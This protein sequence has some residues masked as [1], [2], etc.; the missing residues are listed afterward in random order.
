M[1]DGQQIKEARLAKGL[2]AK[3]VQEETGVHAVTLYRIEEGKT[4]NPHYTTLNAL[5]KLLGI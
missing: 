1:I 2:S 3:K 4:K 5:Y